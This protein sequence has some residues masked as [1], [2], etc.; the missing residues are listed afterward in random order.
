MFEY[1]DKTDVQ[2]ASLV[3]RFEYVDSFCLYF[4]FTF[5]V[6]VQGYGLVLCGLSGVRERVRLGDSQSGRGGLGRI[7]PK[8]AL[9][10]GGKKG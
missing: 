7:P 8:L 10:V 2:A 6:C 3:H 5:V 4:Y 9:K 1:V